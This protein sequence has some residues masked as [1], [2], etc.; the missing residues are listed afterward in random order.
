M[1]ELSGISSFSYKDTS[2]GNSLVVQWIGLCAF[3]AKG[4]GSI[5]ARGTK[6][7]QAVQHGQKKGHQSYRIRAPPL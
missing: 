5:P 1:R 3:T 4:Q 6:M 2:P 7:L